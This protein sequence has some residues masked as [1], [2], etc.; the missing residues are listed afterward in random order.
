MKI[1]LITPPFCQL[2]TPYPA[3]AYLKAWL[4]REGH[5]V[6]QADT[7]L[8]VFL[9]LFSRNGIA[10]VFDHPSGLSPEQEP[11]ALRRMRI[12]K[13]RYIEAIDPVVTFLQGGDNGLATLL[14][15]PGYLPEGERFIHNI[16]QEDAFGAMGITDLARFR[17]TLFLEDLGDYITRAV[18]ED[19]G[20]SRYA[21][22]IALSPPSF[23]EL[24]F[25][26]ET[27]NGLIDDYHRLILKY[28]MDDFE[29]EL[30]GFSIPFPGNL[31]QALRGAQYIRQ[32]HPSVTVCAG[33]GYVNTELR[34]LQDPRLMDYFHYI[35]LDD[36]EDAMGALVNQLERKKKGEE[37]DYDSLVRTYFIMDGGFY[38]NKGES[39]CVHKNRPAPDYSDLPLDSYLSLTDRQNPMHR[40]W[41]EGPWIKMILAHGCYWHRCAFCDTSLDYIEH[42][43]PGNP[44]DLV[45]QMTDLIEQTGRRSFH[46]VD[47]AAPPRLLKELAIE[48]ISRGVSVTWWTNIRFEKQFTPDL[49]RLLA[50]SGCIAVSGGMEV[51]SDR[52]LELMDKGVTVEQ[53]VQ[54]ARAFRE[55]GIMVH[56]YLMY[57]FPGQTPQEL[58]NALDTVRQMFASRLIQSGFWHQFALTAHSPAGLNPE[59]FGITIDSPEE[60]EFTRNDLLFHQEGPD[61]SAFGEGLKT[62]LFNYMNNRGFHIPLKEWFTFKTP[63]PSVKR[64]AVSRMIN[65]PFEIDLR[66]N[67]RIVW[68]ESLPELEED[69]LI[70]RGNS[71]QELLQISPEEGQFF[72]AL[73]E[74]ASLRQSGDRGIL[75]REIPELAGHFGLTDPEIS[76]NSL[77]RE[78]MDYGLLIL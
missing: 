24:S 20:F 74:K 68:I 63:R 61:L 37:F 50:R 27:E 42:Y 15:R 9:S 59:A 29:P 73:L 77:F 48:L 5:Q 19:F 64:H 17:S 41:S 78:L 23:D 11:D 22:R 53:V 2:N 56:T 39:R 65:V 67:S 30:V 34:S 62:S 75:Y 51:A 52:L 55:A 43:D 28:H 12:L 10:D 40:L 4:T 7:G 54:V 46:F 69:T 35:T 26:L 21:E 32:L 44:R 47:E 13:D 14:A 6:R 3:T 49:C 16:P 36:G 31:F 76:E 71:Y 18:D 57:G 66:D 72:L 58:I 45:D 70:F 1:L 60:S 38:F 33:G 8:E 25:R